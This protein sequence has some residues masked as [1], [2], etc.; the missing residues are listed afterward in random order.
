MMAFIILLHISKSSITHKFVNNFL[1]LYILYYG[2][3][4]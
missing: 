3:T 1:K 4:A 2:E